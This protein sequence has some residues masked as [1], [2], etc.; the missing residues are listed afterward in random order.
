MSED[1]RFSLDE[2]RIIEGP[3]SWLESNR[4]VVAAALVAVLLAAVGGGWWWQQH[5]AREAEAERLFADATTPADWKALV[6]RHP[7][8]SPAPLALMQLASEA[9]ERGAL[10]ESLDW[11]EQF[12]KAHPRHALRPAA[13]LSRA[14]LW[15]ALGKTAEARAAY[16]GIRGAR[17]AHPM[18]GAAS[19][20][21]ARV[22]L[23]E[24]NKTAA[25]QVLSEFV[26]GDRDGSAFAAEA[27]RMLRTLPDAAP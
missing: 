19:V 10:E 20:G 26:A 16:E 1:T 3:A 23:A 2:P 24:G 17:P 21:L 22:L 6:E 25:R 4:T 13:E 9:R 27:N 8:T 14:M 15:E 7:K 11:T 12:L 5:A 18:T